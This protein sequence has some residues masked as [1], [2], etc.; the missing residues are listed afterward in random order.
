MAQLEQLA[1]AQPVEAF[2]NVITASGTQALLSIIRNCIGYT[3][4]WDCRYVAR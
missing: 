3:N 2:G 4:T 1:R